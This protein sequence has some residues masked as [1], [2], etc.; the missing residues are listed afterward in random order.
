MT[1]EEAKN[2]K[3]GDEVFMAYENQVLPRYVMGINLKGPKNCTVSISTSKEE[4]KNQMQVS[5][6]HNFSL[7]LTKAD[8]LR[9]I[10]AGL[11]SQ[12]NEIQARI[13]DIESEIA[14]VVLEEK[15]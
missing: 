10:K 14:R 8:A 5:S 7:H 11:V 4:W 15:Q 6:G 2:L 1:F 12:L 9:S 3:I 13:D